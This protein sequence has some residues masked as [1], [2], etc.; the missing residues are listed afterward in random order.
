ME[1]KYDDNLKKLIK[2]P[3]ILLVLAVLFYWIC[4]DSFNY[5]TK[6][7]DAVIPMVSD[8]G[9][10]GDNLLEQRIVI[11]TDTLDKIKLYIWTFGRTNNS[12]FTIA[13]K[14]KSQVL[15]QQEY[16]ADKLKNMDFNEFTLNEPIEGQ[17][18]HELFLN[19]STKDVADSECISF[20]YGNQ[21]SGGRFNSTIN[22]LD[23]LY[24]NGEPVDGQLCYSL[25]GRDYV[26][27]GRLYWPIVIIIIS[28][29]TGALYYGYKKAASGEKSIFASIFNLNKYSFLLKQL[30]SRDFKTRYKRSILGVLWSFLHPLLTMTVQYLVF[31]TLFKSTTE[32]YAVYL[33]C[34][35]ILFSFFSESV[36]LGL[37]SILVNAPLITK[38]YVPKYIYPVSRVLSS[39]VNALISM[40]PLCIIVAISGIRFT[41]SMLLIPMV[42]AFTTVFCIGMSLILS[43]AMVFFR[44]TQFLWGVISQLWMYL[45]PIFYTDAIIPARFLRYYH[46][47][48][49]YQ[50]IY[51]LRQITIYQ[52]V[53]SPYTFIYCSLCALI[54]LLIGLIVFKNTQDKFVLYL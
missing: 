48:P 10:S 44:D 19:I 41:K 11:T 6:Q 36:G 3:V 22:I 50:F 27:I 38:V 40:I 12:K 54:P 9:L 45:T 24:I 7:T 4:G 15:W 52:T 20:Y 23:P 1:T 39:S 32:H 14:D 26:Y 8:G 29:I 13:I 18:G 2:L 43:S 51:F 47:N 25:I 21:L 33:M 30:V 5:I 37:M 49:M 16:S 17:K 35:G 34:G 31:S 42:L 46:M 28:S 53:P